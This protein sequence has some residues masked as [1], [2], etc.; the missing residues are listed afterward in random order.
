MQKCLLTNASAVPLES[1]DTC[2]VV[3]A[4]RLLC[5]ESSQR[6]DGPVIDEIDE[7]AGDTGSGRHGL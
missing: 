6:F 4:A 1:D 2:V 7:G 5:G 3:T